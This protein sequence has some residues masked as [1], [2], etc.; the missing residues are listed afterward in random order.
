MKEWAITP[1]GSQALASPLTSQT[2]AERTILK[3]LED[4]GPASTERLLEALDDVLESPVIRSTLNKLNNEGL[5][6]PA[7]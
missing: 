6:Y 3:D 4:Y 1:A 7:L 5:I 2:L